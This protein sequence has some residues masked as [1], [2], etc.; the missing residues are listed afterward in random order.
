MMMDA[1]IPGET[2]AGGSLKLE[3]SLPDIVDFRP[4]RTT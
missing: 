4:V 3:A 2:E 1:F